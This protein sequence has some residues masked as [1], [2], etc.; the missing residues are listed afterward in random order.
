MDLCR[1]AEFLRDLVLPSVPSTSARSKGS[2][3]SSTDRVGEISSNESLARLS[4]GSKV[5][6]KD[7][8]GGNAGLVSL[9]LRPRAE[10]S[11]GDACKEGGVCIALE[12]RRLLGGRYKSASKVSVGA[13]ADRLYIRCITLGSRCADPSTEAAA[14]GSFSNSVGRLRGIGLRKYSKETVRS[15]VCISSLPYSAL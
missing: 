6:D 1:P 4:R 11:E 8:A 9:D 14:G 2:S 13:T 7:V 15:G 10:S 12:T 3:K 5:A